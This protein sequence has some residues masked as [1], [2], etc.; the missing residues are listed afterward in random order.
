[1]HGLLRKMLQVRNSVL[2]GLIILIQ[3]GN[4]NAESSEEELDDDWF[5]DFLT[6][7]EEMEQEE[8]SKSNE[9]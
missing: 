5:I 6:L 9:Y 7:T 1:M 2:I 8:N 3:L 4:L